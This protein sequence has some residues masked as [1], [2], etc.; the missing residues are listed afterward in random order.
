M[1]EQINVQRTFQFKVVFVDRMHERKIG[2]TTVKLNEREI[3][4]LKSVGYA[5]LDACIL[6]AQMPLI[7][8]FLFNFKGISKARMSIE[9][10]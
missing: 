4:E 1:Y 10:I 9:T 7:A 5:C 8:E 6:A 2:E 3:F